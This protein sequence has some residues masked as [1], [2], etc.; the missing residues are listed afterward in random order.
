MPMLVGLVRG[1]I[2]T[3]GLLLNVVRRQ[4]IVF[5]RDELFEVAPRLARQLFQEVM[6]SLG[7]LQLGNG[8][9]V[10][11]SH[12]AISGEAAQITIQG[13]AKGSVGRFTASQQ[14]LPP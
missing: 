14:H 11:L 7:E 2:T 8:E 3:C 5:R 6:L 13:A 10:A 1:A 4:P 9:A 12:Q